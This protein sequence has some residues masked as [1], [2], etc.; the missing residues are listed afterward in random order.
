MDDETV[1]G[2]RT[3]SGRTAR[4]REICNEIE[5]LQRT[6]SQHVNSGAKDSGD[7]AFDV[8]RGELERKLER[9]RAE[10]RREMI[11]LS[12]G[13]SR[14]L[15]HGSMMSDVVGPHTGN[16]STGQLVRGLAV[17]DWRG[18]PG[19]VKAMVL[20]GGAG[21]AIPGAVTAGIVDLAREQSVVFAAG[22]QVMPVD[23]PTAKVA[24]MLTEPAAEWAP[25]SADREL[26][27]GS[28]TFDAAELTAATAWLYTRLTIEA[29]E[30]VVNLSEAVD[31]S[32]AAQLGLIFDAAGLA[33]DGSDMPIGL[34]NMGTEED[35]IIEQNAVGLV[36]NYRPFV[37]SVGAV[38][39]AHHNPTSVIMTPDMWT[40]INCFEDLDGNPLQMPRA[41]EQLNEYVS[42]YL[43][44]AG[45]TGADEHTAIVGDLSA[46]VFGVRTEA[47]I[48]VNRLGE[49]FR[50][51]AVEVRAYIRF[52]MYL[53][54][55]EAIAVM[56][57]IKV[58]PPRLDD[59]SS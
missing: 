13:T 42:G 52:G 9:A 2:I 49:G 1:M 51:G 6:L 3:G 57:G 27:D 38:K 54:R 10:Y 12:G 41:Y 4:V 50:R 29:V 53:E 48:E 26:A 22:A 5:D 14:K 56:R 21:A 23:S 46:M 39:A 20:S 15:A 44:A 25:E 36:T 16:L 37:R 31:S 11:A 58:L 18:V 8:V 17:G 45:G 30:D 47:T 40:A 28:F 59:E 55:P 43:P 35:R 32:F 19:D 7:P 34:T 33:G 24:R